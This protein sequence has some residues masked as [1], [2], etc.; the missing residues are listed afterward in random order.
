MSTVWPEISLGDLFDRGSA[1]V[2]TGPFGSQLHAHNYV[3]VGT[4]VIP[5]EAIGRRI[6]SSA[7]L[8]CI[9]EDTV[10]RLA[11]HKVLPGDILFARRGVQA[12]GL[13]ALVTEEQAGWVCGT[14]A[15]RLR[16]FG[17]EI[18]PLFL[19][20]VLSTD[21]SI[22]WFKSQA[23]G[24]VM[25][26]LNEGIIRRFML[27]IPPLPTQRAIARILGALDDKIELNRRQNATLEALARAVFQSWF[28]DFDPVRARAAG[29]APVAMDAAT[30][31]LFPD[32]FEER[33]GREVP[34]GWS[35]RSLFDCAKYING[36]AYRNI[37]FSSE[38]YG[39]PVIKIAEIKNG[40]AEQTK[41][42]SK[43]LEPKY[44][45]DDGE[46][47][48]SWSGSPDTSI[49]TFIW[50][51]GLGWLNQ[52]IFKVLPLYPEERSFIYLLLRH[53]KA[54]FV[55]IARDK[56]TRESAILKHPKMW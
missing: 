19:S 44:R 17:K 39:L 15:I 5:T 46:I 40:I 27:R 37:D 7:G 42:T 51:G 13:S 54:T 33:D 49:D 47:L 12:T 45:I 55:E 10:Q 50:S 6:L 43:D 21:A 16:L 14:G 18:D 3:T 35:M 56:Q 25:P 30:A 26:N 31:A 24:A 11:R 36:A 1:S 8:P 4:P 29:R 52:H 48:F 32:G 23:V 28:V 41:F 22:E 34:R 9:G 53:Y 20:F 38:R 2:Q